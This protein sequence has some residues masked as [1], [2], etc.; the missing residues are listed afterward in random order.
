MENLIESN[1]K[2]TNFGY[3]LLEQK[4][5]ELT[6]KEAIYIPP[7]Y[8]LFLEKF[9]AEKGFEIEDVYVSEGRFAIKHCSKG[10]VQFYILAYPLEAWI[11]K[12][13]EV[14]WRAREK[15]YK[16]VHQMLRVLDRFVKYRTHIEELFKQE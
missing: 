10:D 5:A 1:N 3:V 8:V 15:E 7:R 6:E 9:L 13:Y 12:N 16:Y 11:F 14:V 4:I 2:K